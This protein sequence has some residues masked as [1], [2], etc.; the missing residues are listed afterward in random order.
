MNRKAAKAAAF[1]LTIGFSILGWVQ[2]SAA[3]HTTLKN[4]RESDS[5]FWEVDFSPLL[6]VR[7]GAF[8]MEVEAKYDGGCRIIYC[9]CES[10]KDVRTHMDNIS[11]GPGCQMDATGTRLAFQYESVGNPYTSVK[12]TLHGLGNEYAPII[13]RPHSLRGI[14]DRLWESLMTN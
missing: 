4:V 9:G 1:T 14:L 11:K 6:K 5:G 12:V 3:Q 2:H 13:L 7:D 10:A 8:W